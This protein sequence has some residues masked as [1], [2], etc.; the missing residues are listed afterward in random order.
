[1]AI[2]GKL[3]AKALA[4]NVGVVNGDATVTLASGSFFNAATANYIV[5]GDILSLSGVQY[6]V[7]A[8]TSATTLELHA[9]Y[10]GSTA[11]IT[12]A[13]AIRRTAPKQVAQYVVGGGDSN[14]GSLV[15]LD[16]AEA[17]LNEN[18]IRGLTGPGWWVYKT[19]TDAS[20]STRH[21][22]ECIAP[23]YV[24]ASVAGD[25]ADNP[26]AD[27][28]SAITI[29]SQPANQSTQTPAGAILTVDT[30]GAAD[31]LRT[32]GT[33]TIGASDYTTDAAGTGATFTVVVSALG[34]AT[35]TVNDNGSGFVIDET[36]TIDDADLGAGGAANLTF[37]VATVATAAA[38]FSVTAAASTGS[39][40]YQWQRRTSSTAKWTN[41]SGA[42]SS[43][44]ALTGLTTA[45]NGYQYRVK[46][47]SS[48][49]SE[50]VVSNAATLTVT[51][52]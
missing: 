10:A 48:A 38:T 16:S 25:F 35:I 22:S 13:N 20:G 3:D 9:P 49:G 45:S 23:L 2:L 52:A 14:T 29:S 32:A 8:V 43:S 6:V 12:A 42:T 4:N 19:Y 15:F 44:L 39:L 7:K 27:V 51:A 50:E 26:A 33:Y 18:K 34:A 37:D 21:K 40:I 1:M 41:L 47:T 28:A 46:L 36:I 24:T 5:A 11:T 30:I 31:A 17:E